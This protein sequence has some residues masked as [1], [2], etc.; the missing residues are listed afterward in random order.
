MEPFEYEKELKRIH[1][2]DFTYNWPSSST[3]LFYLFVACLIAFTA[4]CGYMIYTKRFHKPDVY[5]Q[6]STLYVPQYN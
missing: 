2:S 6:E 5:I 1:K 3:F 4:G